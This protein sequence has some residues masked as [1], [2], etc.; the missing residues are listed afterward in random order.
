VTAGGFD[1]RGRFVHKKSSLSRLC[2]EHGNLNA[3]RPTFQ[4]LYKIK[5]TNKEK[6]ERYIYAITK[7]IVLKYSIV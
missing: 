4:E 7:V 2:E 6:Y 1:K 3:H 5:Q